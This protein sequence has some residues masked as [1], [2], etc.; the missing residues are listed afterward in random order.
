MR[1]ESED[2]FMLID[3]VRKKDMLNL[4]SHNPIILP[5]K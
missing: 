5:N 2:H 3:H 1:D 4:F